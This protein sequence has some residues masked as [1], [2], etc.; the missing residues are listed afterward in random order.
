VPEVI[1]AADVKR[2]W[3]TPPV[4]FAPG[5]PTGAGPT[6]SPTGPPLPADALDLEL[7]WGRTSRTI[8]IKP[9]GCTIGSDLQADVTLPAPFLA[10]VHAR[11]RREGDYWVVEPASPTGFILHRGAEVAKA[12][13]ADGEVFRL[14]DATGN[15]V[16]LKVAHSRQASGRPNN[17]RGPLPQP[18]HALVIGSAPESNV[19]L[20]HP[21]V[22][23]RHATLG[24]DGSGLWIE[25]RVTVSGTYVNGQRLRGREALKRDDVIQVGPFSARIATTTLEPMD[26]VAG[27]D[28]RVIDGA[29]EVPIKDKPPKVL[30]HDVQLHLRPGSLTAVAGPSGAGKT[31]LM[32]MLSGQ[33]AAS[34]GAVEYNR[35]DLKQCRAAYAGL[36]GFVPQ[37]D[38]VHPDLTVDEALG[39]QAQLRLGKDA[40]EATRKHQI[41]KAIGFVGLVDQRGQQVKTL[42][43]GQRKR[44]S[45][46][47]ELLND[48]E[49]LFLD[50]P[51]SGLDPG[52]DK[53]MMLL[54]RLLA[55][56][57]RTVVLTTHAISHVDVCDN[58]ILVGPGGNVIYAGEPDQ[59]LP[60]FDVQTL[61]DA[62]GLWETKVEAEQYAARLRQEAP[63]K[64]FLSAAISGTTGAVPVVPPVPA[65]PAPPPAAGMSSWRSSGMSST[66]GLSRWLQPVAEEP[67]PPIPNA[68]PK[69][70]F[71]SPAWREVLLYQGRIFSER[72]VLLLTRDRTALMYSLL[73]GA[74]VA[75]LLAL[76]SHPHTFDWAGLPKG[77]GDQGFGLPPLPSSGALSNAGT[78]A[79]VLGTSGVWF[80]MING[81]REL[82]KERTI[83]RREALVG[84]SVSGYLASKVVV[85]GTLAA[86]QAFSSVAVLGAILGLDTHGP[87][88]MPLVTMGLSAWLAN[89]AGIALS[90]FLS[91]V[92]TS[93]DRAMSLVPYLL[94]TQVV[95]C[96][97]LFSLG[98]LTFISWVMP[99]RWAVAAIGGIGGIGVSVMHAKQLNAEGGGGGIASSTLDKLGIYPHNFAG[100][101]LDWFV[102][103]LIIVGG[104]AL[105][106]RAL[107]RQAR[108]WSVG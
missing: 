78:T 92:T 83:W 10:P 61:G 104:I 16:S 24:A 89:M 36:M 56:Q 1:L 57:G 43:G 15:Y 31:T 101:F 73:Q 49:I 34:R 87:V 29:V 51:T 32:R 63:H 25:D 107:S 72:Y 99:A 26:K 48:P 21:L 12:W 8:T 23:P 108:A 54:L 91:A 46:A 20:E 7:Q 30:L 75:L 94:I 55:D 65:A 58:L 35:V 102:L 93:S 3:F 33:A 38:V 85:L 105:T 2:S 19:R 68:V 62:F 95:L 44:V 86:I 4:A 40:D 67:L 71:G 69:P 37:D 100:L 66:G 11:V 9:T 6:T 80:G 96:G 47:T 42:S 41:D 106:G 22:R 59:A 77:G 88:G 81:V 74:I 76:V 14:A 90:L 70:A 18:G 27:I 64:P 79:F 60:W 39:F 52:L 45:I 53:R 5:A 13:L 50:E 98:A 103:A 17:L 97:A 28:V 82:V 84:A